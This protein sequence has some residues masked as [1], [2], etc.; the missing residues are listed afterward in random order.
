MMTDYTKV[1]S[2]ETLKKL[3]KERFRSIAALIITAIVI[4]SSYIVIQLDY[5]WL[6][7]YGFG[8]FGF[9]IIQLFVLGVITI[10]AGKKADA[11]I[12]KDL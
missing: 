4:W 1:Y 5:Q 3:D 7:Y 10:M 2:E 11:I 6:Q 12:K 9:S 8:L